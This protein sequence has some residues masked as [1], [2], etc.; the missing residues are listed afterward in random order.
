MTDHACESMPR[1]RMAF[2]RQSL[3]GRAVV[4]CAD[5]A[6]PSD[7]ASGRYGD[8]SDRAQTRVRCADPDAVERVLTV[9]TVYRKPAEHECV[10]QIGP[11]TAVLRGNDTTDL[12][13]VICPGP[14]D[15]HDLRYA[16]LYDCVDDKATAAETRIVDR[17]GDSGP[18]MK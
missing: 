16:D 4:V 18:P 15:R 9:D 12:T 7:L 2:A 3:G 14:I 6:D 10:N 17:S 1:P 8:R 5:A 11:D 13:V